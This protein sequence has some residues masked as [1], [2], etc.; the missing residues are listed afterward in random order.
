MRAGEH[1][2][3]CQSSLVTDTRANLFQT[4]RWLE[5][6]RDRTS[7]SN[8]TKLVLGFTSCKSVDPGGILLLKH[9]SAQLAQDGISSYIQGSGN[10]M[11]L[12]VENLRHYL[13][14]KKS[15]KA[16]PP[17]GKY[18]LRGINSKDEM[19]DELE[20][21]ALTV[22]AGTRVPNEQVALWQMQ[23]AEVTTNSFQHSRARIEADHILIA[24]LA[25]SGKVQL[26]SLDLG[27][28]IP[29]II[30]GAFPDLA[31]IGD[32]HLIE[33]AFKQGVTSRCVPE[34]QG[35]GLHSLARSVQQNKDGC[36]QVLSR[37]G[38]FRVKKTRRFARNLPSPRRGAVVN[39]TLTIINLSI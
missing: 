22:Q 3:E 26:A 18:L 15:R 17:S 25:S 1:R 21:W 39:G 19:V 28:G 27:H 13:L 38:Y 8:A 2:E 32:G 9:M 24:G 14:P 20:D 16:G 37:N 7:K 11:N 36:L 35:A 29:T 10:A 34:N 31:E 4:V 23:V 30:S 33:H 6:L 12:I 5:G